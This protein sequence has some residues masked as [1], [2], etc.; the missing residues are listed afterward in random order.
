LTIATF[1][2]SGLSSFENARPSRIGIPM[3]A[4]YSGDTVV[5]ST[6]SPRSPG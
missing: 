5:I 1:V 6:P 4:K 3:V 2:V